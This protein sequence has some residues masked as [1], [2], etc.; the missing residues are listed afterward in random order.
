MLIFH[1][2]K[3]SDRKE[4]FIIQIRRGLNISHEH[5][6]KKLNAGNTYLLNFLQGVSFVKSGNFDNSFYIEFR[7]KQKQILSRNINLKKVIYEVFWSSSRKF[8]YLAEKNSGEIP[9]QRKH[10]RQI[11]SSLGI[12]QDFYCCLWTGTYCVF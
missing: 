11:S 2:V 1:R 9:D 4:S 6:L 10:Q 5:S 12:Y 3:T 7:L 8:D